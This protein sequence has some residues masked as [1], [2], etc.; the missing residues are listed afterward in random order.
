[1][2]CR[3]SLTFDFASVRFSFL[4]FLLNLL[5]L[6]PYG[7]TVW[8]SFLIPLAT[9]SVHILRSPFAYLTSRSVSSVHPAMAVTL[10]FLPLLGHFNHLVYLLHLHL[11]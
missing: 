7:T 4:P 9:G 3:V 1:M 8:L 2:R 6:N 10:V 11:F 5:V